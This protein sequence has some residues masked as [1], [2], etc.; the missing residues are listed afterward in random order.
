VRNHS[1]RYN[2]MQAFAFISE[3]VRTYALGI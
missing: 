2:E 1:N 3:G